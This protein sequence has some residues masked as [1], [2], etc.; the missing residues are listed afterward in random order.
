ML[1]TSPYSQDFGSQPEVLDLIYAFWFSSGYLEQLVL[2]QT[3]SKQIVSGKIF[4]RVMEVSVS[5]IKS[6]TY[7]H[8]LDKVM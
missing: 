7:K 1:Y 6:C 5:V 8:N 2:Y 4:S 3:F